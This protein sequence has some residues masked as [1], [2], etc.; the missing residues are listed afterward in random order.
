MYQ[1][2]PEI[3]RLLAGMR[4]DLDL[5]DACVMGDG[6]RV[7]ELLAGEPGLG[8]SLSPDGFPSV[9]LAAYFGHSEIVDRLV[10][11]GV[12]VNAQARNPM[13]VA[14]IHAAVAARDSRSVEILLRHGADPNLR[15]QNEYTPLQAAQANGDDTIILLLK[16][17]GAR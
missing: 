15:Q 4:T 1:R 11:A 14:A 17:H 12:D 8:N 5:F 9:A 16:E 13:K 7:N 10:Q 3:G 2:Q 6:D